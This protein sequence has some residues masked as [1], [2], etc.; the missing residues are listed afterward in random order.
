MHLSQLDLVN[1]RNYVRLSVSFGEGTVVL[2]GPNGAGKSN[3]LESVY[4][5]ATTKSS[6]A[7]SDRE[8]VCWT[9]REDPIPFTRL[10][11]SIRR[12][13]H[14]AHVEMLIQLSP[15]A[16]SA[17]APARGQQSKR[18]TLNGVPTRA[19]DLVGTVHAVMF[20]PEDVALVSDSPSVRRRY[21]D[22]ACSQMDRGYLRVLQQLNRV[23]TQRN[24][25][26]RQ[27]GGGGSELSTLETWDAQLIE[28]ALR[29]MAVR[30]AVLG[31]MAPVVERVYRDLAGGQ[32]TLDVVYQPNVEIPE[33]ASAADAQALF[34]ARLDAV[35]RR[36]RDQG[37]TLVGPHRDDF[38]LVLKGLGI[39]GM[40]DDRADV[41]VYASR[42][43]QRLAVL[44]LKLAE[45]E[46]MCAAQ[47]ERPIVML[48][49]ILSE[50]DPARRAQV[51]RTVCGEGQTL[52]A[53]TD[54]ESVRDILARPDVTVLQVSSGSIEPVPP[55]A[56]APEGAPETPE[57]SGI[58]ATGA[59]TEAGR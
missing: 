44:A 1:F 41:G 36:E 12:S 13:D 58:I 42:G 37:V 55:G 53:S 16:P 29:V 6:R 33:G 4:M 8:V 28:S 35:R 19:A 54:L 9:A 39:E 11:A 10:R 5:L 50:L 47:G 17:H 2:V 49:D 45:T 51:L 7:G 22:I 57:G 40:G 43:Q 30:R 56:L 20:S 34:Q 15:E 24:H 26:L 27:L 14:E 32:P 21:L 59:S 38:R 52:I 18:L 31:R 48:D 3:L 25:L 23:L 46:T